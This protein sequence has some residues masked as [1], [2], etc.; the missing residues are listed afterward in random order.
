[1]KKNLGGFFLKASIFLLPM[2]VLLLIF[3]ILDPFRIFWHYENYYKDRDV[4][5]S[6]DFV[7]T[8]MY[9]QNRKKYGYDS[10]ILG[11][12][13]S[14][15]FL[16]ADWKSY[17]SADS[18]PFHFDA[19]GETVNGILS[20]V[21]LISAQGPL[22]QVLM[23]MDSGSFIT[24][25]TFL[26]DGVSFPVLSDG[27]PRGFYPV[28]LKAFFSEMFFVKY[29]DYKIFKKYRPYMKTA[30]DPRQ[31]G[32]I[33]ETNDR[34]FVGQE[35]AIR[36]DPQSYYESQREAFDDQE[37]RAGAMD[38]QR[39]DRRQEEMLWEIRR[40]FDEKQTQYKIVISPLW[41]KLYMHSD[42]RH[43]LETIF[44]QE[45][46]FNYSGPNRFTVE[47]NNYYEISHY[48]PPVARAILKDMA[49]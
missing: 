33:P 35:E 41:N 6:R 34:L 23:V 14:L 40:I 48:R 37:K 43:L 21:R 42:D 10:F 8:R 45:N 28:F 24:D 30:I 19:N 16:C 47:R 2:W 9:L 27:S 5:I 32:Y 1:M 44:G 29:L 4:E 38:P 13:R 15:A 3:V 18:S 20:K 7:S 25:E 36:R 17:L 31:W 11:N 46:V 39:I 49:Q 26:R 22:R 12:S